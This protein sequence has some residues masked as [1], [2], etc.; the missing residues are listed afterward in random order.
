MRA[1]LRQQ[2]TVVQPGWQPSNRRQNFRLPADV[3]RA[4]R[5]ELLKLLVNN[6]CFSFQLLNHLNFPFLNTEPVDFVIQR[7]LLPAFSPSRQAELT[8]LHSLRSSSS[9]RWLL[10]FKT[11]HLSGTV[12]LRTSM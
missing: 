7:F 5:V 8:A 12:A 1:F 3:K 2:Y 10:C 9:M 6:A 4:N 11:N